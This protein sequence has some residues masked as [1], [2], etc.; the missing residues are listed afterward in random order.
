MVKRARKPKQKRSGR[1]DLRARVWE[2]EKRIERIDT[3]VQTHARVWQ[4]LE[5]IDQEVKRVQ[6]ELDRER[7]LDRSSRQEIRN[8]LQTIAAGVAD[9]RERLTKLETREQVEAEQPFLRVK[10]RD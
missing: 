8:H 6:H 2:L 4:E 1:R 5:K 9:I 10:G 7:E 3:I